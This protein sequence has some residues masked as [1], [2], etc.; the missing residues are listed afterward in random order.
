LDLA[1]CDLSKLLASV[2]HLNRKVKPKTYHNYVMAIKLALKFLNR[3]DLRKQLPNS[4][5]LNMIDSIKNKVLT[6]DEVKRLI[7]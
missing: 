5:L 6:P 2:D 3:Y 7:R 4:K 1:T